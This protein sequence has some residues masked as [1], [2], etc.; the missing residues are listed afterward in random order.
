[1]PRLSRKRVVKTSFKKRKSVKGRKLNKK[2][3]SVRGRKRNLNSKKR[4]QRI[5]S[6]G[7]WGCG[8]RGGCARVEGVAP[9][10]T[11]G[12]PSYWSSATAP[13]ALP[14]PYSLRTPPPPPYSESWVTL[15]D[16][17][18][19]TRAAFEAEHKA[20]A[21]RKAARDAEVQG[22]WAAYAAETHADNRQWSKSATKHTEA[23]DA[24]QAA[25]NSSRD[26]QVQRVMLEFSESH[27]NQADAMA[28]RSKARSS[29]NPEGESAHGH[30]NIR[31]TSPLNTEL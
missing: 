17:R 6:G 2:R 20:W 23:A 31:G 24:F 10:A 22:L 11:E 13:P 1:M 14:P 15:A 12:L 7:F 9:E 16:G 18:R 27:R 25:S 8:D 21:E 4:N 3:K 30:E 26:V 29:T 28:A 5:K 19:L